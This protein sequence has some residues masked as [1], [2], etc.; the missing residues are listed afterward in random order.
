V[1]IGFKE[2]DQG[3]FAA[4]ASEE[5]SRAAI[6]ALADFNSRTAK[7]H[8]GVYRDLAVRKRKT[9]IDHQAGIVARLGRDAGV[10]TPALRL[11]V[12]LIHDIE[13]GKRPMSYETF[14]KMIDLCTSPSLAAARS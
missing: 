2:F 9:E 1:P 4:G 14:Q 13:D 11:L 6:A 7:T 12:S 8:T 3:A 5:R 10:D